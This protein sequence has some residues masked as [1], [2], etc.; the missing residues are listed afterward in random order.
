MAKQREY[1]WYLEPRG[2]VAFTNEL[3]GKN[4]GEENALQGVVCSDNKKRNLWRCPS[5][6]VFTLYQSRKTMR[7]SFGIFCQEGKGQIRRVTKWYGNGKKRRT[8]SARF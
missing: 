5:G 3:L 2:D 4:L 8:D 7:I 1:T 6:M